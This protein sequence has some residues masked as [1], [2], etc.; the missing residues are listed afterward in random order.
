M[1]KSRRIPIE[2]RLKSKIVRETLK[3]KGYDL[4]QVE[5]G[6]ARIDDDLMRLL[7]KLSDDKPVIQEKGQEEPEVTILRRKETVN[8]TDSSRGS[9]TDSKDVVRSLV[10]KIPGNIGKLYEGRGPSFRMDGNRQA[11]GHSSGQFR[12]D[13]ID[14]DVDKYFCPGSGGR[15]YPHRKFDDKE[16]QRSERNKRIRTGRRRA[17]AYHRSEFQ[18]EI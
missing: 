14:G 6:T 2:I 11:T 5:A 4:N 15:T 3:A 10:D 13:N 17:R 9:V 1:K 16:A 8:N 7:E 12:P 18:N